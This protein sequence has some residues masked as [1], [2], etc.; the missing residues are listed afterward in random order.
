MKQF[1]I[2]NKEVILLGILIILGLMIIGGISDPSDYQ[3]KMVD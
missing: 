2:E 3:N 1:F